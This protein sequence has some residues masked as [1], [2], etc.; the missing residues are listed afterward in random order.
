MK[1]EMMI[2]ISFS[3]GQPDDVLDGLKDM[4]TYQQEIPKKLAAIF[5]HIDSGV[6]VTIETG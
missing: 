5:S 6:Q 2:R 1:K 4:L 3:V